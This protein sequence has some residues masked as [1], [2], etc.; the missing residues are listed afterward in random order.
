MKRLLGIAAAATAVIVCAGCTAG[1]SAAELETEPPTPAATGG[2]SDVALDKASWAKAQ[3]ECMRAAGF[4]AEAKA[5]GTVSYEDDSGQGE[6][7]RLAA[8]ECRE[9]YPIDPG[10]VAD[11]PERRELFFNYLT[12]DLVECLAD[13][14]AVVEDVPTRE[15]MYSQMD[16]GRPWNPYQELGDLSAEQ[17][18]ALMASCPPNP[19]VE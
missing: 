10:A 17:L 2:P 9:E 3:V 4:S 13:E 19:P 5:D 1:P 8:D 11:T 7:M 14:G 12:V 15:A 18:E 16:E 6:A